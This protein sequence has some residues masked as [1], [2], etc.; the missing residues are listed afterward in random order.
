MS[1]VAW[2]P[3]VLDL[4]AVTVG[5][6]S[7]TGLRIGVTTA[8]TL[9]YATNSETIGVNTLDV[10]AS[11]AF[12]TNVDGPLHVV[13][14]AQRKQFFWATYERVAT[15]APRSQVRRLGAIEI[16]D[17]HAWSEARSPCDWVT[18][19]GLRRL[20]DQAFTA[21]VVDESLWS[22][23]AVAVGQVALARFAEHGPDDLWQ[24]VPRYYRRSAAEEKR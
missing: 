9:A 5:P 7:F 11:Q 12:Q 14:D 24:L 18:G 6:G 15:T 13:M 16:I 22:P 20:K 8:K 10:V 2:E 4:I 23:N 17:Q 21:R 19:P 1:D 3:Q